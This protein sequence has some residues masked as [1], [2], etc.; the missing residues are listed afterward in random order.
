[1][2]IERKRGTTGKI[3]RKRRLKNEPLCRHCAARGYV[4]AS[5]V[6][7]HIVPLSMG[8]TD[9]DSNIQ[10]LCSRCHEIKSAIERVGGT[11]NHPEW[12]QP[13]LI[14]LTIVCGPPCSGKT[15]YIEQHRG[16]TD[17]VI[18]L[19]SILTEL[20]PPYRHWTVG[21]D[22]Q[23][24]NQAIRVRN[25]MLGEL[26]RDKPSRVEHAWFNVA[27][28]THA[29]RLWWQNKLGGDVV[30]L[31]PGTAECKRRAMQR[32]TP[33]AI[34]GIDS[35]ERSAN[36]PWIPSTKRFRE[37]TSFGPDGWPVYDERNHTGGR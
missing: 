6:P 1:M 16:P 2:D 12:L 17:I 4:S 29:E 24:L 25:A 23:L 27:A 14:P 36:S 34:H 15:T 8:G 13:S 19:D 33:R 3:Q 32:G 21:V 30:L 11:S 7:D 18:D 26:S 5:T 28:P 9:D 37:W 35:W 10:C 20:H 22:S 31:H